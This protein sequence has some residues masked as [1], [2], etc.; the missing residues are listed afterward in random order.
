MVRGEGRGRRARRRHADV[1][2]ST[3][4]TPP[5]HPSLPTSHRLPS[6]AGE[7]W[8]SAWIDGPDASACHSRLRFV[9]LIATANF[10]GCRRSV[11]G[12]FQSS[13][14]ERENRE[15]SSGGGEGAGSVTYS[16]AVLAPSSSC[17][18]VEC[19]AI[20]PL[21]AARLLNAIRRTDVATACRGGNTVR[22]RVRM[23][24]AVTWLDPYDVTA[25]KCLR[26]DISDKK[27]WIKTSIKVPA[28]S[29]TLILFYQ[30]FL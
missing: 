14:R 19:D 12:P 9:T 23:S 5:P 11:V 13:E 3:C 22:R 28:S 8:L 15:V 2:V 1:L 20:F 17:V 29:R 4:G 24:A 25:S 18:A 30:N 6:T 21:R 10:Y 27:R 16:H 26:L 7:V